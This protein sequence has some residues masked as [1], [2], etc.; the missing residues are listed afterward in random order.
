[1]NKKGTNKAR[2]FFSL[3]LGTIAGR[4]YRVTDYFGQG[5]KKVVLFVGRL[6]EKKGVTYLLGAME[7]IDAMLV[8]VGDG[9]LR[10]ELEIQG[11]RINE[12]A[13]WMKVKLLSHPERYLRSQ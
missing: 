5:D 7:Q 1:M 9:P 12:R 8:V 3:I 4:Q 2:T 11:K 13:G 6:A 10:E